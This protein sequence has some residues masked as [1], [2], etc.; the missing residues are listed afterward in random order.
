MQHKNVDNEP[1]AELEAGGF[2]FSV[3]TYVQD[4]YFLSFP[5]HFHCISIAFHC[6]SIALPVYFLV[7]LHA[8]HKYNWLCTCAFILYHAITCMQEEQDAMQEE[9]DVTTDDNESRTAAPRDAVSLGAHPVHALYTEPS[10]LTA[11]TLDRHEVRHNPELH[12]YDTF[13]ELFGPPT[14]ATYLNGGDTE[15]SRNSSLYANAVGLECANL[16]P[17]EMKLLQLG[18]KLAQ[19]ALTRQQLTE[20]T[21]FCA[22]LKDVVVSNPALADRIPTSLADARRVWVDGRRSVQARTPTVRVESIDGV[23]IANLGDILAIVHAARLESPWEQVHLND[24][25]GTPDVNRA[26]VSTSAAGQTIAMSLGATTKS[27]SLSHAYVVVKMCSGWGDDLCLQQFRKAKASVFVFQIWMPGFGYFPL[28]LAA[29]G[30]FSYDAQEKL[31]FMFQ[32]AETG[33]LVYSAIL[34]ENFPLRVGFMVFPCDGPAR[35]ELLGL[36]AGNAKYSACWK[37]CME[38][39]SASKHLPECSTCAKRRRGRDPVPPGSC[40]KCF[41]WDRTRVQFTIHELNRSKEPTKVVNARPVTGTELMDV[42]NAAFTA[43]R[44]NKCTPRR[45]VVVMTQHCIAPAIAKQIVRDAKDKHGPSQPRL[46]PFWSTPYMNRFPVA[47]QHTCIMGAVKSTCKDL[48]SGLKIT[49][50]LDD[51]KRVSAD[52]FKDFPVT[53]WTPSCNWAARHDDFVMVHW[54]FIGRVLP[55]MLDS[56]SGMGMKKPIPDVLRDLGDATHSLLAHLFVRHVTEQELDAIDNAV[57]VF[58]NCVMLF[59]NKASKIK[60]VGRNLTVFRRTNYISLLCMVDQLREFGSFCDKAQDDMA[61]ETTNTDTKSA[62]DA[63]SRRKKTAS[64]HVSALTRMLRKKCIEVL[65]IYGSYSRDDSES[66][67][68]DDDEENMNAPSA[69]DAENIDDGAAPANTDKCGRAHESSSKRH[70]KFVTYDDFHNVR[71]ALAASVPVSIVGVDDAETGGVVWGAVV[72]GASHETMWVPL[73]VGELIRKSRE[74]AYFT[75]FSRDQVAVP[76]ASTPTRYGMLLPNMHDGDDISYLLITYDWELLDSHR[77]LSR[78]ELPPL[79]ADIDAISSSA[80]AG[81]D[82]G[83]SDSC[84]D[85]ESEGDKSMDGDGEHIE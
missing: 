58:L 41:G 77:E 50:Q 31:L 69:A 63:G 20:F 1:D 66:G 62:H 40:D 60:R 7:R 82:E 35:T 27:R 15:E 71:S 55:W 45:G 10:R 13:P 72:Q 39:D 14:L 34:R 73:T 75:F 47:P 5:L 17:K 11:A 80:S 21:E 23:A 2:E 64:R 51:F 65:N 3:R 59:D 12:N 85:T 4:A 19:N 32:E 38:T 54:R 43:V 18:A 29:K 74:L 30:K 56:M 44:N 26:T 52:I 53:E 6:I 78:L 46:P 81:D 57:K 49:R 28:V 84:S 24:D 67:L 83:A 76:I 16:T 79:L 48:Q 9:Q 22:I 68:S 42:A 25:S 33:Y 36:S 70:R 61:F 37:W 8:C